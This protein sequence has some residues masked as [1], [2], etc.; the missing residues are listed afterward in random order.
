MKIFISGICG[1]VGSS[2]ARALRQTEPS[3]QITGIDNFS[4]PGSELNR[5]PLR[6]FGVRVLHADVRAA[7]DL[8]TIGHVDWIIDAAANP[9]VL[10]GVDGATSSRQIIE[11]NLY[12]TVNLLELAKRHGAGFILL[13][14]SR[15]YSIPALAELP[16]RMEGEAFRLRT[17]GELPPGVSPAGVTE[18]F[19][20][21]PPVSLYGS[22][23][24][25]SEYLALEMGSAFDFPVWIDRCGVLAGAGQFGRADQGIFTFWINAYLRQRPLRYIGFD[26]TGAQV[27]DCL[28]PADL[29][30]LLWKQ[31]NAGQQKIERVVNVSA[32]ARSAMSLAELSSWCSE[33]FASRVIE[34]DKAPRLF[35]LPWVVLDS[36]RAGELWNW[37]PQISRDEILQEIAQHAERHPHWL[38]ISTP[39]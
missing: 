4:R 10:A 11:H 27:R 32:G 26:G 6:A 16:L 28:H 37:Q 7:S 1:F 20:T 35:D 25:A 9:S 39:A 8:D 22:T 3:L 34:S 12:G 19:S 31:M 15:V 23:K 29:A 30:A 36:T 2:I 13:S 17:D 18:E 14:T 38:E 33:R 5:E 24:L 21:K